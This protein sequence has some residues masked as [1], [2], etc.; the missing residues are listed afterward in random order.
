MRAPELLILVWFP[1]LAG[2]YVTTI[3]LCALALIGMLW[4]PI[5]IFVA[6]R[7][8]RRTNRSAGRYAI[9]GA[10]YSFLFFIPWLF[11]VKWIS[12]NPPTDN[13]IRLGYIFLYI[14]WG[15]L[16]S[17]GFGVTWLDVPAYHWLLGVASFLGV[18]WASISVLVLRHMKNKQGG[19]RNSGDPPLAYLLPVAGLYASL[20][21][22]L[23]SLLLSI[24]ISQE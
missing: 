21:A 12:G 17:Y 15:L 16:L 7:T 18:L 22:L 23:A 14:A 24:P 3:A 1:I 10:V 2:G 4:M 5:S 19:W 6:V 9:F 20:L 8:A 13:S 11:A